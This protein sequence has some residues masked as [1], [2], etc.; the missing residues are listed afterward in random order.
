[1]P[2][3]ST[4]YDRPGAGW[5]RIYTDDYF[6]NYFKTSE[7]GDVVQQGK[8]STTPQQ[9]DKDH[10]QFMT[11]RN[12]KAVCSK[13]NERSFVIQ[14]VMDEYEESNATIQ[15]RHPKLFKDDTYMF[16]ASKD[17]VMCMSVDFINGL[18]DKK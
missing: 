16:E 17:L 18:K 11:M 8:K 2:T 1:M 14:F 6:K 5:N 10:I 13:T 15:A 4:I 7:T 3:I 9:F 12:I